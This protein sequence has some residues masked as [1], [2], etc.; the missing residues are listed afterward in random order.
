MMKPKSPYLQLIADYMLKQHYSI[1][2]IRT[3]LKWISDYIEF[4]GYSPQIKNLRWM[5]WQVCSLMERAIRPW[6]L[7][8]DH[9][10]PQEDNQTLT[11]FRIPCK[12]RPCY[13]MR[14]YF[15]RH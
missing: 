9:P 2:S 4:V 6:L 7:L 1:R 5:S 10:I 8:R 13:R 12:H 15:S 3:Y 11:S 14:V